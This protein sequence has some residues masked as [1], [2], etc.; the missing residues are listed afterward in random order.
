MKYSNYHSPMY[1][2]LHIGLLAQLKK[3]LTGTNCNTLDATLEAHRLRERFSDH[4]K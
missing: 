2:N 4:Y 1:C 3:K